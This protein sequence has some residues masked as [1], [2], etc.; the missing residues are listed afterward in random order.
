MEINH[1]NIIDQNVIS[2]MFEK[3]NVDDWGRLQQVCKLFKRILNTEKFQAYWKIALKE[4][5]P[6]LYAKYLQLPFQINWRQ[7]FCAEANKDHVIKRCQLEYF[8]NPNYPKLM[9]W[10]NQLILREISYRN[11]GTN[12]YIINHDWENERN[13][14]ISELQKMKV[15]NNTIKLCATLG[16]L[17]V[18]SPYL[19][20]TAFEVLKEANNHDRTVC[21]YELAFC[22]STGAR[23]I[24][25]DFGKA[26]VY[27]TLGAKRGD[28]LCIHALGKSY[29]MG[30]GCLVDLKKAFYNFEIAA[31]T[32]YVAK[33]ELAVLYASGG[34]IL[35]NPEEAFY[36]CKEAAD[37]GYFEAQCLLAGFYL[38]GFGTEKDEEKAHLYIKTAAGNTMR[39]CLAIKP[40]TPRRL[41]EII[42]FC[43]QAAC[44]SG[45]QAHY[46]MA[47]FCMN[48]IGGGTHLELGFFF[49]D[50]AASWNH[51]LAKWDM[52]H[53]LENGIG[54]EKQSAAETHRYKS[55]IPKLEGKEGCS[56][57][58]FS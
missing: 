48:G 18:Y 41:R 29:Q 6:N 10:S 26:L 25:A 17:L 5:K 30:N 13:I 42:G 32:Y 46:L 19:K 11:W 33:Y 52:F 43:M 57:S 55:S 38:R 45:I 36:W 39:D 2:Y 15:K 3:L 27:Y 21:L 58:I 53:C 7:T 23:G 28:I 49:L 35:P 50:N 20:G 9:V 51:L 31:R 16:K 56:Y 37:Q 14:A 54:C 12:N 24:F 22:Y 1:W 8:D 44:K 4:R 47:Y 40:D 34:G